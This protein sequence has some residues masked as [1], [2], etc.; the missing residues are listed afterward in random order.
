MTVTG[1]RSG[2]AIANTVWLVI[3]GERL[4]LLLVSGSQTQ[5][6]RNVLKNSSIRIAPATGKQILWRPSSPTRSKAPRSW[7][8]SD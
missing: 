8:N 4:Y 3:D 1:R 6:Y 2:R 7:T 5:W